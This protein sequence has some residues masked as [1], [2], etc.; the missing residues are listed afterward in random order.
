MLAP[1]GRHRRAAAALYGV[2]RALTFDEF[3]MWLHL[4]G[5][6]WQRASW[7][8]VVGATLLALLAFGPAP[9]RWPAGDWL[10]MLLVSAVTLL[11]GGMLI[12]SLDLVGQRVLPRVQ[13]LEETAPP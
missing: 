6:Y 12:T 8:V 5:G 2:G 1:Q 3:G 7:G 9:A 13:R 11:F 10:A 4:G